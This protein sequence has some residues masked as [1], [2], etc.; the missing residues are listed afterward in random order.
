MQNNKRFISE[1]QNV[2]F[3][4]FATS[5]LVI[6]HIIFSCELK[7]DL[8]LSLWSEFNR[9]ERGGGGNEVFS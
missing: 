4:L 9:E 3:F 1:T 8:Y 5:P 7:L 6:S 2:N